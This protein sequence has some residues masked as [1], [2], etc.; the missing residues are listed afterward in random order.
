M[1]RRAM[2]AQYRG[3]DHDESSSDEQEKVAKLC[4]MAITNDS[5]GVI[6]SFS[7]THSHDSLEEPR[8][9]LQ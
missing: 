7:N 4:L 9:D 3:S 5:N 8:D 6:S 2:I 1:A